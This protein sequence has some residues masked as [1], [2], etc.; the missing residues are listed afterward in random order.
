MA[1]KCLDKNHQI[2][3][4]WLIAGILLMVLA[5][6]FWSGFNNF[7]TTIFGFPLIA[8]AYGCVIIGV[9]NPT[10]F[11]FRCNSKIT[12]L[13]AILSY[14]IYLS[15]K[16]VIVVV[17]HSIFNFGIA[18][19]SNFMFV[20]CMFICVVVA[21]VLFPLIEQPFLNLRKRFL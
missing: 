20:L 11:L 10:N 7:T 17:Q 21:G 14:G 4:Y 6:F 12:Q 2:R 18:K 9:L 8:I 19:D 15:H 5:Y 3:N 13:I 16:A 1:S